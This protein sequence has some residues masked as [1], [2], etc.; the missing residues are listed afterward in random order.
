MNCSQCGAFVEGDMKFCKQCGARIRRTEADQEE[1]IPSV[2]DLLAAQQAEQEE[3]QEEQ[4]EIVTAKKKPVAI[5]KPKEKTKT[6]SKL[7]QNNLIQEV[8]KSR[9]QV[10][11]SYD[12]RYQ[13]G[14]NGFVETLVALV[15][16]P[17]TSSQALYFHLDQKQTLLYMGLLILI[18][19]CMSYLNFLTLA[20][21]VAT[22]F[23]DIFDYFFGYGTIQY[24]IEAMS[25]QV[26]FFSMGI[27]LLSL[28]S[29][30]LLIFGIYKGLLK[31]NLEW[32]ECVQLMLM[33]IIVNFLGKIMFFIVGL[34][35]VKLGLAIALIM[36]LLV[37]ALTILQFTSR[38]GTNAMTVYGVPVIYS[39]CKL[40]MLYLGYQMLRGYLL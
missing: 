17:I 10:A 22:L 40:M 4:E 12:W 27:S 16:R 25:I 1:K 11:S 34:I 15:K 6:L 2:Q 9:V 21:K 30:T 13:G 37:G 5:I 35:S 33:P 7:T 38:L 31:V 20:N 26:L 36:T 8:Q 3:Q 18:S 19:G 28:V 23:Y 39:A 32:L 24:L 29:I 14:M